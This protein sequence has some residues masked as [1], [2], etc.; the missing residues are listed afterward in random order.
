MPKYSLNLFLDR[1]QALG[2]NNK[3]LQHFLNKARRVHKGEDTW[4]PAKPE[5]D[6]HEFEEPINIG[7]HDDEE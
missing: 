3:I 4:Q 6:K 5:E 1:C 7:D 2:N